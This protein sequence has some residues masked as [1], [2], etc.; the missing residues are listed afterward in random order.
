V[1]P[2]GGRVD[3]G[4][5]AL[6]DRHSGGTLVRR[7][8][9]LGQVTVGESDREPRLRGVTHVAAAGLQVP[10]R[11][12]RAGN[13][14]VEKVELSPTR[15]RALG[16]RVVHLIHRCGAGREER[17]TDNADPHFLNVELDQRS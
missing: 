17:E 15:R 5:R 11:A 12:R 9:R 16:G 2:P 10:H 3:H 4:L 7:E 6:F 14:R 13:V 8:P 1:A